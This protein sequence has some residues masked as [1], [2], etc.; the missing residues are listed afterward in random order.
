VGNAQ[1]FNVKTNGT[2]HLVLNS[3][4]AQQL[5]EKYF[6]YALD[7]CSKNTIHSSKNDCID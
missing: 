5:N 1:L 6:E 7:G 2:K 3:S 4:T